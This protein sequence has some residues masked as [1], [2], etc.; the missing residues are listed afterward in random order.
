M[1]SKKVSDVVEEYLE[2]IYKLEEKF[3]AAKT[4]DIVKSLKLSPGTVTNTLR[5][6]ERRG[7]I[8]HKPYRGVKLTEKGRR[9][10]LEV[11]RR[12]RLSERLLTDF[13]R[14][15]WEKAHEAACRLEHSISG[16]VEKLIERA[17][18]YPKTCPHG[19]PIPSE[20]GKIIEVSSV[21]LSLAGVGEKCEVVRVTDE[22]IELLQ[23]LKNLGL[24]PGA[25]IEVVNIEPISESI[26]VKIG[27]THH[28][29]SRSVA[30]SIQVRHLR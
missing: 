16:D 25:S 10:A 17:L 20:S 15:E 4:G 27:P 21:P 1:K 14:L 22:R 19:N 30:S 23:H 13:L 6:L 11:I 26:T 8:T 12:H 9:I 3:K 2:C 24:V 29:L 7:L 18:N 28:S 5:R